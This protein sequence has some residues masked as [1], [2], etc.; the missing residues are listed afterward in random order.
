MELEYEGDPSFLTGGIEALLVTMGQLK[1]HAGNEENRD[2]AIDR[3]PRVDVNGDDATVA[4]P[5]VS[6][7]TIA[8]HLDAKK[9]ADIALCALAELEIVQAKSGVSRDEISNEMKAATSY[10]NNNMRGGNLTK[11]LKSLVKNRKINHLPDGK[12]ALSA[13]EKNK[14]GAKI[15]EI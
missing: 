3:K 14:I 6:T 13:S 1:A 5:Q 9:C 7:N 11:A 12:Y 8:A 15:A 4:P 2:D 10:Y